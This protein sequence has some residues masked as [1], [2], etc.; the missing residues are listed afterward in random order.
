MYTSIAENPDKGS[1]IDTLKI[2]KENLSTPLTFRLIEE[3]DSKSIVL[4]TIGRLI[5]S[6]P[7]IFDYEKNPQISGKI[8]VSSQGLRDTGIYEISIIDKKISIKDFEISFDENPK[9]GE[10]KVSLM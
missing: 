4:D 2:L 7:Q 9:E 5:V 3:S 10:E 1:T 8:V 6:C